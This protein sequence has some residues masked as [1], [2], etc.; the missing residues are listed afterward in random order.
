MQISAIA[1]MLAGLYNLSRKEEVYFSAGLSL[2][3]EF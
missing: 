3:P 2:K 1:L